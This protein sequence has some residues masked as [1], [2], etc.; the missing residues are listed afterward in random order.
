[1]KNSIKNLDD[2]REKSDSFSFSRSAEKPPSNQKRK[3]QKKK[4]DWR[5]RHLAEK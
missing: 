4:K 5:L 1:M 2:R 3:K